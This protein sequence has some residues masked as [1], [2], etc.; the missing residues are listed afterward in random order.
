MKLKPTTTRTYLPSL[1]T[2]DLNFGR[3]RC[4]RIISYETE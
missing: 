3:Q 1:P 2:T 4:F